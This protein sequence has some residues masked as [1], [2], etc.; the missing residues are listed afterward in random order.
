[1]RFCFRRT[2][3]LGLGIYQM[4][5]RCSFIPEYG[6]SKKCRCGLVISMD[7]PG[8]VGAV[9]CGAGNMLLLAS[10]SGHELLAI[11]TTHRD[12]STIATRG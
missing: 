10:L 1:M 6:F 11:L 7:Y 5:F 12:S 8:P 9:S 4:D 2:G 3:R